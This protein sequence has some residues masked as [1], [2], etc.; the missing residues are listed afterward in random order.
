[1]QIT[2]MRNKDVRVRTVNEIF[3]EI[4]VLKMY[5]WEKEFEDRVIRMREDE[6]GIDVGLW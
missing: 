4:K 5:A 3:N 2:A 6:V 1:M